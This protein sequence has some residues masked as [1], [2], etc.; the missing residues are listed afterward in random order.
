MLNHGELL[1]EDRLV[2]AV[3]NN[4]PMVLAHEGDELFGN[5][6]TRL[7][8]PTSGVV[9]LQSTAIENGNNDDEMAMS[10][11][12]EHSNLS[13]IPPDTPTP[14]PSDSDLLATDE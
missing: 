11:S 10:C 12:E 4:Y 8:L 3:T 6:Y 1:Q 9:Y 7:D 2:A 13:S 5:V 14:Q